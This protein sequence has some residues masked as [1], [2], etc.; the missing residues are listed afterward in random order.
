M[1]GEE[2]V[3]KGIVIS[4][5]ARVSD[6]A[7]AAG[8]H[9]RAVRSGDGDAAVRDALEA[10]AALRSRLNE[11]E[12][13]DAEQARIEADALA[14]EVADGSVDA[15]IATTRLMRLR[16]YVGDA[17]ALASLVTAVQESVRAITGG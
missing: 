6:S 14:A 7:L 2:R 5:N 15:E 4:G 16:T 11:L 8:D 10:L 17:T 3:N 12:A 9:A 13:A 1:T